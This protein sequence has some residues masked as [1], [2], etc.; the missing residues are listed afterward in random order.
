MKKTKIKSTVMQRRQAIL[1]I[2]YIAPATGG[3]AVFYVVPFILSL[4]YCFTKGIGIN[5]QFVLLDNFAD[6][7]SNDTFQNAAWNSLK[8]ILIG[9]TLL[10]IVS[11]GF[12][13]L[14][15]TISKGHTWYRMSMLLPLVVP[16]ASVVMIWQML[17]AKDGTINLFLSLVKIPAVN[18]LAEQGAFPMVVLIFVWKNLGYAMLLF[19]AGLN[20]IPKMYY[21]AAKLDG[22]G[23]IRN[24]FSI[25]LRFLTPTTLFVF[26]ISVANSFKIF[27]E[28]Y[29]LY[30][31]YP[32]SQIY[33]L[34]H[35]M[36]NNFASLNY[37]RLASAA[38][39]VFAFVSVFVI[40]LLNAENRYEYE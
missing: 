39:I 4:Y 35:F 24:F 27:R 12:A 15:N 3:L 7:L 16:V 18:W 19:L 25:T 30:S 14:L 36:Q 38:M 20:N 10:M 11:L 23:S 37:P 32:P 33:M 29:L 34:Q 6:L 28:A 9:V 40:L 13:M 26:I 5:Y 2:S 8:F 22:G 31:Q 1:G 17:F 21:E